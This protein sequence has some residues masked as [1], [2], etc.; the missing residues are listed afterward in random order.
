LQEL[1]NSLRK[2][3][4]IINVIKV[5]GKTAYINSNDDQFRRI[6]HDYSEIVDGFV[7]W[8]GELES[9]LT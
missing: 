7:K 5:Q 4:D 3:E 9:V 2:I 1:K 8:K 6:Y